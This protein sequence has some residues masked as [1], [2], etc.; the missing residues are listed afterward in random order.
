MTPMPYEPVPPGVADRQHLQ[1][2]SICH[3][4]WGGLSIIL[5]LGVFTLI[6]LMRPSVARLY[7]ESPRQ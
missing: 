4:V 6:V 2:L 1:I 3:W 5:S 7:E